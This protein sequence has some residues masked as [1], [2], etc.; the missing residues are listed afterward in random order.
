MYLPFVYFCINLFST[1]RYFLSRVSP[2]SPA[3]H[4]VSSTQKFQISVL[5]KQEG[6]CVSCQELWIV[7]QW[8][9]GP[10]CIVNK[11]NDV[12]A[13]PV[14]GAWGMG[15]GKSGDKGRWR[16]K[17]LTRVQKLSLKRGRSSSDER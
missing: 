15:I 3:N 6:K 10:S 11:V 13:L 12:G 5:Q 17:A 8:S 7:S 2:K 14:V 4:L 1:K 16:T 9:R